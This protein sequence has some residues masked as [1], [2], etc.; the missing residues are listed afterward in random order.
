MSS[1]KSTDSLMRYLRIT[2]N[3]SISGSNHKRH[4]KNIGYYHGYKGYRFI[5]KPTDKI[6]FNNFDEVIAI[7][8]FDMQLKT[9]LYPNIMF[10]ETALKNYVLEIILDE[11]KTESFNVIYESLL[12]EYKSHQIGSHNYK[13]SIKKRLNLYNKIHSTLSRDYSM[14]KQVVQHYYHKDLPVPIWAIFEIISLGEF[15]HFVSCITPSVKIKIG[16]SLDFNQSC[17]AN[18]KLLE[19]AIYLLQDLRNSI[20]HN[21][22]IFD[23]RI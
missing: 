23:T 22:V 13:D 19:N 11:T 10:I 7:N 5:R 21:D 6:L 16:I 15:G 18:G 4:L 9:L 14:N 3:I 2:H 17:N 20:A 8:S 12:N 1:V